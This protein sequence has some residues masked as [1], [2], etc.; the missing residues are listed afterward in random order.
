G[1]LMPSTSPQNVPHTAETPIAAAPPSTA[2]SI[3]ASGTASATPDPTHARTPRS[4]PPWQ[5][6][7]SDALDVPQP[8]CALSAP[9]TIHIPP[10]P[11]NPRSP[12]SNQTPA[13]SPAPALHA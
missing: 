9:P 7:G 1:V 8:Q 6:P 12:Q 10:P 2:H 11:P 5:T 4:R 13:S 3:P